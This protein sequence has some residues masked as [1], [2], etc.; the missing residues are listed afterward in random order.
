MRS[1]TR[2]EFT[3]LF[4]M[5]KLVVAFICLLLPLIIEAQIIN[6]SESLVYIDDSGII[7]WEASQE[8]VSLFGANYCLPSACD[9]RAAKYFSNDLKAE[10]EKDMSHFVRM[11]WNGLRICFWGDYQ[12]SDSLGNLVNNDH[13]DLMDY[14]VY[15]AGR[16][17]IYMLLSPI[18]TY[19]SQWPDAMDVPVSGF[20]TH[21]KKSELGTNPAAISA[22]VNYIRQLLNHVNPYT[23][24]PLKDE[25]NILFIEM[26][27]EPWHHSHDLDGSVRYLN[28]LADAVRS[29][30]CNKIIFHNV[31]QDFGIAEAIRKSDI[32][33]ASFAW[34]P[35]GLVSGRTL[36]GNFLRTV[37]NYN[38]M[39]MSALDR[40]PRIV[41]E[42]DAPD[43]LSAEM[44]PAMVRSFRSVGAQFAAMFTYDMLVS[45]K[46]NLGWQTHFLNL[47]YSPQKAAGAI[48]AA[49]AMRKLPLYEGY[50]EYPTNNNFGPFSVSYEKRLSEYITEEVFMYSGQTASIV[51]DPHKLKRI[52]GFH[53][54][55]L[56]EYQGEG[57]YFLDKIEPGVWRL[58]I[59]PDAILVKDPFGRISPEK[60]VSRLLFKEHTMKIYLPDIGN[61]F[62]VMPAN[63]R[64]HYSTSTS[65][66]E[67]QI[68]PGVYTLVNNQLEGKYTL[69]E[70]INFLGYNEYVVPHQDKYPLEIRHEQYHRFQEGQAVTLSVSVIDDQKIDS[71]KLYL[72]SV[73][74]GFNSFLMSR[75]SY[76]SYKAIIPEN[77]FTSGFYEYCISIYQEKV[78]TTF[79]SGIKKCPLDWDFYVTEFWPLEIA[80]DDHSFP[81]FFPAQDYKN[82]SFTRIGDAIRHGIFRVMPMQNNQNGALRIWLPIEMDH[83][84]D[85]YTASLFVGD[86]IANMKKPQHTT[87]ILLRGRGITDGDEAW[88]TFVESDGTSWTCT[89]AFTNNWEYI[90]ID[91]VHLKPGKGVMLPQGYPGNW[92]YWVL[93]PYG[94]GGTDDMI[95]FNN[96]EQMQISIRKPATKRTNNFGIEISFIGLQTTK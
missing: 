59:Y 44:Y 14:L 15:E 51:P 54:S 73:G 41:Y 3:K 1:I 7:R 45:A 95:N 90:E 34:Y 38:P 28:A 62:S 42:F 55:S 4:L 84:L 91:T 70:S 92:N 21:F 89:I 33:G 20:S 8:E 58:E 52:V 29:V 69:P 30:D 85:D 37:D 9:Y 24:N 77:Y 65:T 16:R 13:L 61:D 67:F 68:Y 31:S 57:L 47:V 56:V 50:G 71:V 2:Q 23:G 60:I 93:P 64:N 94:R 87:K 48:I 5:H 22:Q 78:K 80:C 12:N 32:Q 49:E 26:I 82:L 53:S 43:L 17:G 76:Y 74:S 11:G 25:P 40:M 75:Y 36:Q 86:R 79:P 66:G 35:S 27:N 10:I 96:V 19:S 63:E 81:L 6:K 46:A 72:R 83:T 39:N 18:V 88:L